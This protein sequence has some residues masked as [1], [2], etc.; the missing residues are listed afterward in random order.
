MN[1]RLTRAD[2]AVILATLILLPSLYLHYWGNDSHG[3][4]IV[5][6]SS[7]QPAQYYSLYDNQ[8][9]HVNG[10]L[11]DNIIEIRD[12][13]VRFIHSP[14]QG[15]QCIHTGWLNQ[16]G[17]IAACLPNGVTVQVIGRDVRFDTVNF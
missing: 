6:R 4:Q 5:I 3:E 16:D 14:C 12:A 10:P 1:Y 15:Q 2:I 13:Q 9:I 17:Q 7:G 8:K 11:G